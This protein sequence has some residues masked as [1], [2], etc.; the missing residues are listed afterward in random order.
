M[1]VTLTNSPLELFNFIITVKEESRIFKADIIYW[2]K[3]RSRDQIVRVCV[4]VS[5]LSLMICVTSGKPLSLSE[6]PMSSFTK[7]G[8]LYH[9]TCPPGETEY[10]MV[11]HNEDAGP[12]GMGLLLASSPRDSPRR[13]GR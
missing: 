4:C 6:P 13:P 3:Q 12:G 11:P 8:G 9:L 10:E 5:V 7:G 1:H 2:Q